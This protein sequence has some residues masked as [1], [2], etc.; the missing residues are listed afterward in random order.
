MIAVDLGLLYDKINTFQLT[1][2]R[3]RRFIEKQDTKY[4]LTVP[5]EVRVACAIYKLP[6]G[7]NLLIYS[8]MFAI[9][10]SIVSVVLREVVLAV[11]VVFKKQISWPRCER[12]Q[13]VMREFEAWCRIPSVYGA[14]D[15]SHVASL[16]PAGLDAGDY[17][18]YKKK[19]YSIFL[20][21]VVDVK[22]RFMDLFVELPGSANDFRILR[23]STLYRQAMYYGLSD[24]ANVHNRV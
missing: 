2:Y 8:E 24:P 12:V 9:S 19:T 11:N 5:I 17:Y 23:L 7:A 14:I 6:Q 1:N 16:K 13:E 4:R 20:Q 3:L 21:V 18:C 15:G 10:N 22:K